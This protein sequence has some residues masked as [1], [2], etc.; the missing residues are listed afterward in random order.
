[1][2]LDTGLF[3]PPASTTRDNPVTL[4]VTS[5]ARSA[6]VRELARLLTGQ[7]R[8]VAIAVAGA[9]APIPG[10]NLVNADDASQ[11]ARVLDG[12]ELCV[13]HGSGA[14]VRATT[15]AAMLKGTPV[16][17][18]ARADA[19]LALSEATQFAWLP[20]ADTSEGLG[21]L[22]REMAAAP[23]DV[24]AR[25]ADA[26]AYAMAN[27]SPQACA[28]KLMGVYLRTLENIAA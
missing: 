7:G 13:V 16:A 20:R 24:Q 6:E 1:L 11:L 26:R 21:G 15:L 14:G 25:A 5:D 22:L 23:G 18:A 10:A 17:F 12:A 8:R 19:D 4:V 3:Q 27:L 28:A 2:P 9:V